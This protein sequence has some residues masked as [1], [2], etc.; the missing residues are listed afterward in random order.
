MI[1]TTTIDERIKNITTIA[2]GVIMRQIEVD[3]MTIYEAAKL[4]DMIGQTQNYK[5]IIDSN[6]NFM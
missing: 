4:L 3:A 2:Y 1:S 6:I 5:K